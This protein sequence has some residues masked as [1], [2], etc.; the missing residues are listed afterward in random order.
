MS[1][2]EALKHE[3]DGSRL[4]VDISLGVFEQPEQAYQALKQSD[5][6]WGRIVKLETGKA[7]IWIRKGL[8]T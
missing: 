1:K 5:G 3:D 7:N 8:G 4:G 2:F 6:T